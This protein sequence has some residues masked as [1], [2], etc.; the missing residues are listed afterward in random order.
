LIELKSLPELEPPLA[1]EA[2]TLA[3]MAGA[4]ADRRRMPLAM[5]AMWLAVAV[6][7][8]L[9]AAIAL[10]TRESGDV[11]SLADDAAGARSGDSGETV[12]AAAAAEEAAY[13][14]LL[15]QS[16]YL[17]ELLAALPQREV[18]RVSTAGTIVGLEQQVALIDA[19]LSSDDG[20]AV[21]PE[22]RFTLMRDR[23]EAMNALVNVRYAQSIAF[24][25]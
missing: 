8:V 20:R 24:N 1:L 14:D 17:E 25:Y 4:R 15:W 9:I 6:T 13:R 21:P 23:V 18:M 7:G 16:A 3:A 22:Y 2:A 11:A 12:A 5:A 10:D 19:A